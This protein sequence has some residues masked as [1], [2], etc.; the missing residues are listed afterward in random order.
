MIWIYPFKDAPEVYSNLSTNGGDED[1]IVVGHNQN[2]VKEVTERMA[3]SSDG[4]EYQELTILPGIVYLG[5][6]SHA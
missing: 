5:F 1:Y 6:I 4:I 3:Y 2:L